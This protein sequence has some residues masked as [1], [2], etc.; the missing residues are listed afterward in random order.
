MSKRFGRSQKRRLRELEKLT[1][2]ICMVYS[3]SIDPSRDH[4]TM[5]S[6]SIGNCKGES[7]IPVLS[8]S[9][10]NGHMLLWAKIN[11]PKEQK[12]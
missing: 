5:I 10:D 12:R 4:E 3:S 1:I 9:D 7:R 8:G 6:V 2:D 11:D